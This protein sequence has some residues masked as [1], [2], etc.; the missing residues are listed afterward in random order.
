MDGVADGI[1]GTRYILVVDPDVNERFTMS[2]LLQ[3][4]GYTV[5]MASTVS[6]GIDFLCV[7][8]AVAVFAE[9][10]SAGTELMA[11]LAADARFRNVPLV[12]VTDAPD[13]AL[14]ERERGGGLAAVLRKPFDAEQVFKVIQRVIE[15]GTRQ[16]IRIATALPAS[17]RNGVAGGVDG[18]VTVLSQYGLFFR[19]LSPRPAQSTATVEFPLWGR[20]ISINATVLYIVSFDE[21]PFS[22]P[23]MGM[24]F[25]RIAPEDSALV[26]A[27]ILEHISTDLVPTRPDLGYRGGSA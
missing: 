6:E 25:S 26:R 23:G 21:G 8:P 7:A 20:T 15:K 27:Y 2:M 10:G 11:R 17:L 4:F 9:A 19:T 3:R 12:M 18:Y 13:Q 24:K 1:G 5:Q 22:E 14:E 16:N